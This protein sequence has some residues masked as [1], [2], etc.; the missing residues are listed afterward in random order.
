MTRQPAELKQRV[1]TCGLALTL[2]L[3]VA[4]CSATGT[5]SGKITYDGVALRGGTVT[6]T[7]VDGQGV[8]RAQIHPDGTYTAEHVQVG[9]NRVTVETHSTKNEPTAGLTHSRYVP[10]PGRY[11]SPRSSGLSVTVWG[12]P[13]TFDIELKE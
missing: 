5:L 7:T 13:Q 12:G 8:A 2:C 1:L 3:A 10:I 6:F 9:L 11:R 4:G